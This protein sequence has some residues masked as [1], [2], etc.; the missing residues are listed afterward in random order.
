M[1][2]LFQ[3][4]FPYVFY[5]DGFGVLQFL[6]HNK[7]RETNNGGVRMKVKLSTVYLVVFVLGILAAGILTG[8]YGNE[9]G[10]WI[11]YSFLAAYGIMIMINAVMTEKIASVNVE[12]Y[13]EKKELT[14]EDIKELPKELGEEKKVEEPTS[15]SVDVP[16]KPE[17][18]EPLEEPQKEEQKKIQLTPEQIKMAN[19]I[20]EYVSK[21][22]KKGHKLD[23]IKEILKKAYTSEFID[24]VLENTV[25]NEPELPDMG[26]PEE[27]VTPETLSDKVKENKEQYEATKDLKKPNKKIIK[28]NKEFKCEKCGKVLRTAGILRNHMRLSKKCRS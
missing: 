8:I 12:A 23:K 20:V 26:E 24:F 1:Y 19:N 5:C 11:N 21:N 3:R 13:E 6:S 18:T 4:S 9:I 7:E 17:P 15:E 25:V 14:P 28:E 16:A 10:I 27:E 22:L 2:L